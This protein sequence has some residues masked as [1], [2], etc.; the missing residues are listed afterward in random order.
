MDSQVS[1]KSS[2][3]DIIADDPTI[4]PRISRTLP[5]ALQDIVS[6]AAFIEFCDIMD[7]L[8]VTLDK[9][10][11]QRLRKRNWWASF[12][13]NVSTPLFILFIFIAATDM[14]SNRSSYIAIGVWWTMII[15][16]AIGIV[17]F[18]PPTKVDTAPSIQSIQS[19]CDAMTHR[20]LP[21]L[22]F[23][24]VMVEKSIPKHAIPIIDYIEVSRS[25]DGQDATVD[26]TTT[27]TDD[28]PGTVTHTVP[29]GTSTCLEVMKDYDDT[30]T[31]TAIEYTLIPYVVH[32]TRAD[33]FS[34]HISRMSRTLPIA[35]HGIL[36]D[37]TFQDFCTTIDTLL[38]CFEMERR[39][40]MWQRYWL[41]GSIAIHL[42]LVP[43]VFR[44]LV[45]Y[46]NPFQGMI[47]PLEYIL[48][49]VCVVLAY[50]AIVKYCTA[51]PSNAKSVTEAMEAIRHECELLTNST[52]EVSFHLIRSP[53]LALV[54]RIYVSISASVSGST[55]F[56]KAITTENQNGNINETNGYYQSVAATVKAL[57]IGSTARIEVIQD[58]NTMQPRISR[59]L[60]AELYGKVN[61][62]SFQEF[63]TNI[64][65]LLQTIDVTV[66]SQP[67]GRRF[68]WMYILLWIGNFS[69]LGK[70]VLTMKFPY[71]LSAPIIFVLFIGVAWYEATYTSYGTTGLTMV[72]DIR[73]ECDDMT[74]RTPYLSFHVVLTRGSHVPII[75]YIAVMP[76][77][78]IWRVAQVQKLPIHHRHHPWCMLRLAKRFTVEIISHSS[79]TYSMP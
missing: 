63:C 28:P 26:H 35:L 68:W 50:V 43:F 6:D 76:M 41:I 49:A 12:M 25:T 1:M 56:V 4:P 27:T 32:W 38:D 23:R 66:Y 65:E 33:Y 70:S 5:A 57:D 45:L 19:E 51:R 60:P 64:D 46:F 53:G 73:S 39:R 71:F 10:E 74:D 2:R 44:I 61:D 58:I 59:T 52:P 3:I 24:V 16:Y 36:N 75:E 77:R 7:T 79:K 29:I 55:A 18:L 17:R 48:T 42:F 13:P 9:E 14:S 20:T 67:A 22:T 54:D 37:G 72:H 69:L 8:L 31:T 30:I 11:C 15:L 47:I 21:G 40:K 34:S 78:L 62:D